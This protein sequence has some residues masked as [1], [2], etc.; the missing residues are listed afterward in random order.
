[1]KTRKHLRSTLIA[2]VLLAGSADVMAQRVKEVSAEYTFVT[3]ADM[4]VTEAKRTAME[5]ARIQALADEFG[6]TVSQTNTTQ[7]KN[8]SAGGSSLDF[9]SLGNSEVKGEWLEDTREPKYDISFDDNNLIVKVTVN[10]KA[11]EIVTAAVEIEALTLRNGKERKFESNDFKNGD[12]LF[13]LFKSPVAGYVAI[14]LVDDERTTYCLLP[15][16]GTTDGQQPVEAGREYV[17]FDPASAP[18]ATLSAITDELVM[19]CSKN[20]EHNEIYIIFSSV[21][22][23][24]AS[25]ERSDERLPRNLSFEHFQR[26]LTKNRT[27]DKNMVVTPRLIRVT[28]G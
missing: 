14:Y 18:D 11:R 1:M 27:K 20:M 25:D 6:T 4:S 3:S 8:S 10:G 17:F 24:K 9:L 15:Y 22:F 7:I 23:V 28:K 19:T 12:D 5:R 2:L 16:S 13:V 21:P 26:W